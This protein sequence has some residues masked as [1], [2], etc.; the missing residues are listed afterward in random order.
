MFQLF[1]STKISVKIRRVGANVAAYFFVKLTMYSSPM[2]DQIRSYFSLMSTKFAFQRWL[3]SVFIF[4]VYSHSMPTS[5]RIFALR[6]LVLICPVALAVY[7]ILYTFVIIVF[8]F[9]FGAHVE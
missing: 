9:T 5:R 7:V 1:M 3:I 4:K 6:A 8:F 2:F